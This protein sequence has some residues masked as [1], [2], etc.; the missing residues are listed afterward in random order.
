MNTVMRQKSKGLCSSKNGDSFL[1]FAI[2]I[3]I[4]AI[5]LLYGNFIAYK[6]RHIDSRF[7]EVKF[8]SIA[9]ISNIQVLLLGIPVV[10][11][12][13]GDNMANYFVRCGVLFLNDF[14]VL[15]LIFLPKV[16]HVTFKM[17]ILASG[18]VTSQLATQY[19][20]PRRVVLLRI[21]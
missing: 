20:T 10:I 5:L 17:D 19:P 3:G 9:M 2:I 18:A 14:T 6:C 16:L 21:D 11:I 12:V 1:Y 4:H 8:I 15:A 13:S 7:A